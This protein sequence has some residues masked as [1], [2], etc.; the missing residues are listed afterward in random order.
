M[1]KTVTGIKIGRSSIIHDEPP[2]QVN[3]WFELILLLLFDILVTK[4]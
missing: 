2:K 4:I 3:K 1:L